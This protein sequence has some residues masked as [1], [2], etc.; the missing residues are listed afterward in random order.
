MARSEFPKTG[1]NAEDTLGEL[2]QSKSGDVDWRSGRTNLYVQF[3]GDDV[4]CYQGRWHQDRC[5]RA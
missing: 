5:Q 2:Q 4:P 3:G 1:R